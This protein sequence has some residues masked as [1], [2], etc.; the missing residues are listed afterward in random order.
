MCLAWLGAQQQFARL[1]DACARVLGEIGVGGATDRMADDHEFVVGQAEHATH[2]FSRAHEARGHHADGWDALPFRYDR[3]VQTARRAAASIADA[4]DNGL[5]FL[6]F[7]DNLGL[8]GSTIVGLGA[9]N[10]IGDAQLLSQHALQMPEIAL[11][12]LLA[13][14]NESH[15]FAAQGDGSFSELSVCSTPFVAGIEHTY[16]HGFILCTLGK[17]LRANHVFGGAQSTQAPIAAVTALVLLPIHGAMTAPKPPA[18]PPAAIM[19]SWSGDCSAGWILSA[20]SRTT[21]PL[22]TLAQSPRRTRARS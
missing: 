9:A 12:A 8:C 13:I 2:Q 3:V 16:R 1:I 4:G 19:S 17:Y 14:G 11:C 5:P 20:R 18:G 21:E 7:V 22:P 15:G 10:D 6:D